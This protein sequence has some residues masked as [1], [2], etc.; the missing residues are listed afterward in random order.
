MAGHSRAC[1]NRNNNTINIT[2]QADN[3]PNPPHAASGLA[4]P[5]LSDPSILETATGQDPS[6]V[7]HPV[8]AASVEDRTH[9]HR[10]SSS[11]HHGKLSP[12]S[13]REDWLTPRA[14]AD[15]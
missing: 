13:S 8:H 4:R 9:H 5:S 12:G 7:H 11:E 14:P 6:Y 3:V 10:P 2:Q 1:T 15:P